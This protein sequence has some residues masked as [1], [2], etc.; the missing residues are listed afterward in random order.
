MMLSDKPVLRL[1]RVIYVG[2]NPHVACGWCAKQVPARRSGSK[3]RWCSDACRMKSYRAHK[4]LTKIGG[5][6]HGSHD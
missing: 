3:R 6:Q 2:R 5:N 1:P 4:R